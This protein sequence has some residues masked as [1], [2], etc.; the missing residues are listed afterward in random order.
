MVDQ[1]DVWERESNQ[2]LELLDKQAASVD[3]LLTMPDKFGKVLGPL[4]AGAASNAASRIEAALAG[5]KASDSG[6]T[7]PRYAV[8]TNYV[9][10]A[11]LAIVDEGE[12]IIPKAF[13]PWAGGQGLQG[14]NADLVAEVRAL[15][16]QNARLESRLEAIAQSTGQMA[17]QF[18]N[19]SAGGNA[20]AVEAM[21]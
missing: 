20:L 13:N 7:V 16:E 15:R 17:E 1:A 11:H 10:R 18:D 3:A 4:V 14:S 19:V 21:P 5:L 2:A 9:S 12:A 6:A 8:G